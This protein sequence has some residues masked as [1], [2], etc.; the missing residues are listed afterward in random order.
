MQ[1]LPVNPNIERRNEGYY[2]VDTRISLASVAY[3]LRRGETVEDIEADFPAI[4]SHE[5]LE[6]VIAFIQGHPREVEAYLMEV[7]RRWDEARKQN[8]PELTEKA[9]AYRKAK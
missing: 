2:I 7:T 9:R 4:A 1:R 8:P 3:A 6:A 5:K